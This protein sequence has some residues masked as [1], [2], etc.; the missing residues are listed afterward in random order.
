MVN[1]PFY[2]QITHTVV[3]DLSNEEL[4]SLGV[5]LLRDQ[6]RLRA[7]RT[8]SYHGKLA[9]FC[10]LKG[11]SLTFSVSILLCIGEGHLTNGPR[12]LSCFG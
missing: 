1:V 8:T 12:S 9:I 6:R 4:T 2:I 7:A 5:C 10:N 11:H 3:Q